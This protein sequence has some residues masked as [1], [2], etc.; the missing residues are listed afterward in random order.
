MFD[1]HTHV[2]PGMD[3]GSADP[4]ESLALLTLLARQGVTAVAATPHF[5]AFRESPDRFLRRRARAAEQLRAVWTPGLPEVLL[6]AEVFYYAGISST[7]GL[8][9]LCL[10]DT[11]YLLLEMP[12]ARWSDRELH[13]VLALQA[14]PDLQVVLAHIDRYGRM[15]RRDTWNFLRQHGV[16]FQ[17]NAA[18]LLSWWSRRRYLPMLK[19]NQ[20]PFLGS[21]CHNMTDRPPKL[22]QARQILRRELGDQVLRARWQ[23]P[24]AAQGI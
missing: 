3:D 18:G 16:Q 19:Q 14:R 9:R 7:D 5:Y 8:D 21:D 15:Q 6:G 17:L 20:I 4:A 1:F 13:E 23:D 12:F 10:Q 2:L 11:P 24:R 22:D